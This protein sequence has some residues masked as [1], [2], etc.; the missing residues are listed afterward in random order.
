M[1]LFQVDRHSCSQDGVC[2]AVCSL[3]LISIQ[4]EGYPT[5]IDRAE[6]R[7]IVCGHCV[8]V[9]PTGSLS[10][11]DIPVGQ[12]P[13]LRKEL[14]LTSDHC[15]HFL[16]SRRSIRLYEDKPV[17]RA[18]IAKLIEIARCAPSGCNSQC[19]EWLVLD[20]KHDLNNLV[21]LVAEWMRWM[22]TNMPEMALS[23]HMDE[24]L[25]NWDAGNDIVLLRDAP[26][27]II[28]HAAEDNPLA[29]STCTIALTYLELAATSMG[30]GCCWAG[31]FNI[32]ANNFPPLQ[33]ALSLP[34]G[35]QCF[36]AMMVGYPAYGYQRLPMRKSPS[37]KWRD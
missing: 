30:L 34:E 1:D 25:Q 18:D 28:A 35:H 8:A 37:I 16:R 9:C 20:N 10:H 19:A 31:F 22:L 2:A 6:D 21:G 29:L 27:A 32:A 26:V 7:C 33:Q 14:G 15:E 5:P 11:R 12:C 23:M 36:G 4:E 17:P 24:L 13:P 3:R